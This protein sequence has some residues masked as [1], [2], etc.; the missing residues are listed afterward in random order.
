[1]NM[2]N[3]ESPSYS[4]EM[5]LGEGADLFLRMRNSESIGLAVELIYNVLLNVAKLSS[6]SN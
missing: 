5:R 3:T 6:S 2:K 1:M 4:T